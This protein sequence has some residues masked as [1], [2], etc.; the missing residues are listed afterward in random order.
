MCPAGRVPHTSELLSLACGAR[1]AARREALL[2]GSLR[3]SALPVAD[4]RVEAS[5]PARFTRLGG[6]APVIL[7]RTA[8][9]TTNARGEFAMCGLPR[10]AVV[11]LRAVRGRPGDATTT[12]TI[13]AFAV[14]TEQLLVVEP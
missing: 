8:V 4:T 12:V 3:T 9:A 6:G 13:P 2:R 11:S 14:V 7:S 10:G 1:V 5:W